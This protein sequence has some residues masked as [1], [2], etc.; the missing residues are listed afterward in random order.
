VEQKKSPNGRD[1]NQMTKIEWG[2]CKG[3]I[4]GIVLWSKKEA[5]GSG[6]NLP[7]LRKNVRVRE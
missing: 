2:V 5:K 4:L 7:W 1:K 6:W 3:E